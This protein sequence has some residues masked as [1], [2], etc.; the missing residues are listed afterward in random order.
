MARQITLGWT[1]TVTRDYSDVVLPL[2]RLIELAMEHCPDEF[3]SSV[4]AF[5]EQA[6]HDVPTYAPLLQAI[7][8]ETGAE[9]EVTVDD[10]NN[11]EV[12]H[13]DE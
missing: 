5:M 2:D 8:A 10:I 13:D 11:V 4:A 3:E 6:I 1:E 12:S 7:A 9:P